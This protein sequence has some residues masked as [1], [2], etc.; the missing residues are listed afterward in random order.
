MD[1]HSCIAMDPH[2]HDIYR[3]SVRSSALLKRN[4]FRI[5]FDDSRNSV[6][7]SVSNSREDHG[8]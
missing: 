5:N 6:A 2:M 7:V 4:K 8:G 3:I 1:A